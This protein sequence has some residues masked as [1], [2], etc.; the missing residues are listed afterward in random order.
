MVAKQP[1]QNINGFPAVVNVIGTTYTY[2]L[3]KDAFETVQR[4]ATNQLPGMKDIPYQE[5]EIETSHTC[6]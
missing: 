2:R 5:R 4:R 3:Y 6:I 1:L